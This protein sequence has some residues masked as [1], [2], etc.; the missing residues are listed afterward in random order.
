MPL[1]RLSEPQRAYLA[2]IIDGEGS[3]SLVRSNARA[4][5]RYIYPYVRVTNTDALLLEWLARLVGYGSRHYTDEHPRRKVV[6]H[7]G[8][9]CNEAVAVLRLALPYLV[10][11]RGRA[12]LAL[13]IFERGARAKRDAGGYF[14]NGHPLPDWLVAEREAAFAEMQ[15]LNARGRVAISH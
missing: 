3:I 6:H 5:A 7:V 1:T 14:G 15:R 12:E 8:W 11:K 10:I 2:G 9:A 13:H 4:S